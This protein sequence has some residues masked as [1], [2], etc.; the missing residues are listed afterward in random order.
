LPH[1]WRHQAGAGQPVA[2]MTTQISMLLPSP[3]LLPPST[4]HHLNS[5]ATGPSAMISAFLGH[6]NHSRN[7]AQDPRVREHGNAWEAESKMS[8]ADRVAPL[9][10][11]LWDR[12][13]FPNPTSDRR[14]QHRLPG[15]AI[16]PSRKPFMRPGAATCLPDLGLGF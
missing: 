5:R 3:P 12:Y 7:S 10:G 15:I 6:L 8:T 11:S 2:T 4:G 9:K 13:A 1:N 14:R 16:L